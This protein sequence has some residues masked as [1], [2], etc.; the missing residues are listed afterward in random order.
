MPYSEHH[1]LVGVVF[2]ACYCKPWAK[3][4]LFRIETR[5]HWKNRER[6]FEPNTSE[7]AE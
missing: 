2:N 6:R 4:I 7:M 1:S 5:I 3:G